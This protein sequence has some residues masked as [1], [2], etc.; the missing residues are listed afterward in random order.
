ME[1][2]IYRSNN[3]YRSI[4]LTDP[5]SYPTVLLNIV[6]GFDNMTHD[7]TIPIE[8]Q[9]ALFLV[10]RKT[11]GPAQENGTCH[12]KKS[13]I[14]LKYNTHRRKSHITGRIRLQLCQNQGLCWT[15]G[16][17]SDRFQANRTLHEA[18]K[19]N[20]SYQVGAETISCICTSLDTRSRTS[21]R[22]GTSL[23]QVASW[24]LYEGSI[25]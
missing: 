6:N 17:L 20:I 19:G 18:P 16:Q 8:E 9:F 24:L 21:N 12:V 5:E 3:D 23:G 2:V 1:I 10:P 15:I 4:Q 22:K 14:L 7:P 11:K 25:S 13:S